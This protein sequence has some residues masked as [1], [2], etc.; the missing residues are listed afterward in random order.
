MNQA[1]AYSDILPFEMVDI[2]VDYGDFHGHLKVFESGSKQYIKIS[3]LTN[4]L[5]NML[6]A[7]S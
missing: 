6:L 7:C 4:Q 1:S 2:G 5:M 3:T